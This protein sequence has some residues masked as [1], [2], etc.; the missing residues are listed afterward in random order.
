MD[1]RR[2]TA[3][4]QGCENQGH[5]IPI[6]HELK[7]GPPPRF[8]LLLRRAGQSAEPDAEE[9]V[10]GTSR[11]TAVHQRLPDAPLGRRHRQQRGGSQKGDDKVRQGI[12]EMAAGMPLHATTPAR[13]AESVGQKILSTAR[14]ATREDANTRRRVCLDAA[15]AWLKKPW[16]QKLGDAV[17]ECRDAMASPTT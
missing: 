12:D 13:E 7:A 9:V 2:N 16:P 3:D 17:G 8:L 15:A 11:Q 1:A 5:V 6:G 10:P 14:N 4:G